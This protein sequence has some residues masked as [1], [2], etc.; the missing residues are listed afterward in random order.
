MAT[1]TKKIGTEHVATI[2]AEVDSQYI[3]RVIPVSQE[4]A[5]K[6]AALATATGMSAK[7]IG[8]AMLDIG[9]ASPVE[10]IVER[11]QT[12]MLN[13]ALRLNQ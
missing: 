12:I 8:S 11:L 3:G 13:R 9:A 10:P 4:A 1:N 7:L 2:E 5:E 6:I